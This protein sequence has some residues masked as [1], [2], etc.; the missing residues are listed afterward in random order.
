MNDI[1]IEVAIIDDHPSIT[2][3]FERLIETES[4][5]M[6]AIGSAHDLAAGRALLQR[7]LPDVALLDLDLDGERGAELIA[8]FADTPIRFLVLTGLRD[9][10]MR[11]EAMHAGARGV[12][13]KHE[14]PE[15]I[16]RAIDRVHAGELWLDRTSTGYR[17]KGSGYGHGVGLCVIGAGRRAGS[18]ATADQILKFYF[19]GLTVGTVGTPSSGAVR[20]MI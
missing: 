20:A 18:G 10:E 11:R 15:T 7:T 4:P 1:T 14:R 13:G 8:E 2:W 3:G 5:R 17:F 9:D 6:R 16:V 19:P 12:L